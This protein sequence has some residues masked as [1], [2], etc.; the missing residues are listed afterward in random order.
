MLLEY[1]YLQSIANNVC[2]YRHPN[3]P[4]VFK[5]SLFLIE[6]GIVLEKSEPSGESLI[7]PDGSII[8][9]DMKGLCLSK[10]NTSFISSLQR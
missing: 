2:S 9:N 5:L 1:F 10:R 8:K 6:K 3:S 4:Q 7:L